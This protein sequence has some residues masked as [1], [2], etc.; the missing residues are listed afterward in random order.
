MGWWFLWDELTIMRERAENLGGRGRDEGGPS[1][2]S[3][4][5]CACVLGREALC[6]TARWTGKG[7]EGTARVAEG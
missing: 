3:A 2:S 5:S 1:F 7:D 4:A 6:G